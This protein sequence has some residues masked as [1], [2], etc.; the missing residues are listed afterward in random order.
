MRVKDPPVD[1][2]V[3]PDKNK[4]THASVQVTLKVLSSQHEDMF[5]AIQFIAKNKDGV[6]FSVLSQP[7]RVVSKRH[8]LTKTKPF[9]VK[10]EKENDINSRGKKR[11]SDEQQMAQGR[12][13]KKLVERAEKMESVLLHTSPSQ[14]FTSTQNLIDYFSP[15]T[16]DL[17]SGAS[18]LE[19][20]PLSQD[21]TSSENSPARI[22]EEEEPLTSSSDEDCSRPTKRMNVVDQ[23]QVS[24][25]PDLTAFEEFVTSQPLCFEDESIWDFS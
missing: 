10:Q 1:Y 13:L 4:P 14:N 25:E 6:S 24:V 12:M 19:D 20:S 21:S 5:F 7:I 11:N 9:G 15:L 23:K 17:T 22:L 18:S 16:Q 2:T 3:S 8:Q